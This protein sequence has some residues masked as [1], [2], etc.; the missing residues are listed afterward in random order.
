MNN[1]RL[2]ERWVNRWVEEELALKEQGLSAFD[3]TPEELRALAEAP[4]RMV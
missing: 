3:L 2:P 1:P 4:R